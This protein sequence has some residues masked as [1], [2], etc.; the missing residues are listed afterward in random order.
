MKRH[1]R[2][3]W[4]ACLIAIP[5][6][7]ITTSRDAAWASGCTA[8]TPKGNYGFSFF[9]FGTPPP[10]NTHGSVTAPI[11]GVGLGTFDGAGNFSGPVNFSQ[12]GDLVTSTYT[13][14]YTVNSDCT[15]LLTGT[16]GNP[17]FAFV[18]VSVGTEILGTCQ[19]PGCAYNLDMKKQ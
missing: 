7:T 8:A 10:N 12:N 13:A 17:S 11:A 2:V 4:L 6:T 1:N 15:G 14:T 5:L 9:G 16:N 19:P 3:A 18:I